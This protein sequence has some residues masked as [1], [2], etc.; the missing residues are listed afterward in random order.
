MKEF[1]TI[2]EQIA[3]L[4]DRGLK[5]EDKARAADFL[6]HNNYYRVSGYSLTLRDHDVFFPNARFENIIDIYE[7]DRK[8][9]HILLKRLDIIEI[10]FKSIYAYE[11]SRIYG[12]DG[13]LDV[14]NFTAPDRYQKTMGKVE[15]QRKSAEYTEPFVKHFEEQNEL[16][17]LWAEV[18]LFTFSNISIL[19]SISKSDA[20][21]A[22]AFHYGFRSK[23]AAT[24]L[25]QVMKSM[26]II[27]N[28]CAHGNRL[29]NRIF[30]QKPRLTKEDKGL[31]IMKDGRPDNS[32]LYGFVLLMRQLLP[33]DEFQSMKQ[34]I[35]QAQD[36]IPFVRM[37]YY[38]F[39]EDWRKKL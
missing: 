33:S 6:L 38:G 18:E 17:P 4:E 20:Q 25:G 14:A 7:F 22:V 21:S 13:Y 27:R 3:L 32:H 26:T 15:K 30:E 28:L 2:L 36:E 39:R 16:M 9:R 19:Y 29:F 31:L 23:G 12:P 10:S 37:S 11:F 24:Q 34:E 1:K 35:E 8:L 5:V